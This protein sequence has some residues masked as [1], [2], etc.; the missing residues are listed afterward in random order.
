MPELG[1]T[2]T[3]AVLLVRNLFKKLGHDHDASGFFY[4]PQ[5]FPGALKNPR[6]RVRYAYHTILCY[7]V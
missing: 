4:A 6:K 7:I 1:K 2:A 5:A 3:T